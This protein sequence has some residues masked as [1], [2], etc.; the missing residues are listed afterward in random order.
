MLFHVNP[1]GNSG[2]LLKLLD[3]PLKVDA[4]LWATFPALRQQSIDL[5]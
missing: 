3:Q 4:I 2:H 1:V 5:H